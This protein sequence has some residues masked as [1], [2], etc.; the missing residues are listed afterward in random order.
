MIELQVI[1][2][3]QT[4]ISEQGK[5]IVELEKMYHVMALE[6]A[7]LRKD[8]DFTPDITFNFDYELD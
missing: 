4:L 3:L 6:I 5:K 1:D 8:T 2:D 7:A